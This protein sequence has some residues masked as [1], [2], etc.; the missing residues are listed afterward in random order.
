MEVE[1]VWLRK[2]P[3]VLCTMSRFPTKSM[4]QCCRI[5]GLDAQWFKNQEIQ[6]KEKIAKV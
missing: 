2:E 5:P 6:K 3:F 1:Q 4:K